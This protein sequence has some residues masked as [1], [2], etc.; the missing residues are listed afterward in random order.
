MKHEN[1]TNAKSYGQKMLNKIYSLDLFMLSLLI[2]SL[3]SLEA[4]KHIFLVGYLITRSFI[5]IAEINLKKVILSYWDYIFIL[6]I[7]TA[8]LSTIYAGMPNLMD[9]GNLEEWKGYRVLLTAILTGWF[10]S[11]SNYTADQY[12]GLFKLIILGAIPPLLWGLY[13]YLVLQTKSSLE[14][15]SVGHVNHSA[16]YLVMIF[17]ATLGWLLNNLSNF[18]KK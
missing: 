6:I 3:P 4:P 1:K 18:K 9:K 10:L 7:L 11:R 14:L 16:I 13:Q 17:G 15:H 12:N 2:L 8:L 5:E